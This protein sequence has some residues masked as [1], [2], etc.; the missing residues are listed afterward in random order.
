MGP[1]TFV[2]DITRKRSMVFEGDAF[3][4]VDVLV[5]VDIVP[6]AA[7]GFH[8]RIPGNKA[9]WIV[10]GFLDLDEGVHVIRVA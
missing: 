6:V 3:D 5:A 2:N 1:E 8:F 9:L 7:V 4:P 10:E